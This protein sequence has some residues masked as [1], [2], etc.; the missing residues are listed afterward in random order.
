MKQL[1][2]FNRFDWQGFLANKVLMV[3][4]ILPVPMY[5]DGKKVGYQGSKVSVCIA[6]DATKYPNTDP[7]QSNYLENFDIKVPDDVE[8]V[9][10]KLTI[11]DT[12]KVE[13]CDKC[14]IYGDFRNQLSMTVPL[15][16]LRK[17]GK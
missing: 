3:R 17:E 4:A 6:K 9:R 14:S 7:N 2:A 11:G 5:K 12:I 13:K 8:T 1:S 10:G 16:G 15:V